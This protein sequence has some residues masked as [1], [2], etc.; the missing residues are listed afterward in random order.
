MP[1]HTGQGVWGFSCCN[2]GFAVIP[3]LQCDRP[4][5]YIS[6]FSCSIDMLGQHFV[7]FSLSLSLTIQQEGQA[8]THA[9]CWST[10]I[11]VTLTH[12]QALHVCPTGFGGEGETRGFLDSRPPVNAVCSACI[13]S[14]LCFLICCVF[15]V[16]FLEHPGCGAD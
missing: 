13:S 3:V 12:D 9:F 8:G 5:S 7:S 6:P 15:C 14:K 1:P 10:A 11:T 2:T 4:L 16:L